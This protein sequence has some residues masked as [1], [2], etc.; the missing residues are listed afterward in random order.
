M[1]LS[2]SISSAKVLN[3]GGGGKRQ[4]P[5][6]PGQNIKFKSNS[7]ISRTNHKGF[8]G[9]KELGFQGKNYHVGSEMT[10]TSVGTIF[11]TF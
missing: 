5:Y 4:N 11:W 2:F 1:Y 10:T 6:F 8:L 9:G 3:T 7:R